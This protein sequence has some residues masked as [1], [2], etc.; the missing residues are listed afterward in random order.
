MNGMKSQLWEFRSLKDT[1]RVKYGNNAMGEIK[2]HMMITKGEFTIR[3]V[4]C[5]E[6]LHHNLISVPQLVVGTRLNVLFT[7]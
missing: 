1:G 3:K 5:V 2:G 7:D 6:G 4:A